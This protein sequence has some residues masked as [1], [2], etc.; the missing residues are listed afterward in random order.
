MGNILIVDDSRVA[1]KVLRHV[2]ETDGHIV[3][4]EAADGKQGI[5][6]Y[7][8]LRPDLVLMDMIMPVM[9]GL[10]CLKAIKQYDMWAKV[11]FVSASA[12]ERLMHDATE[13]GCA[14]FI[15]KPYD[16]SVLLLSIQRVL[17]QK[18]DVEYHIS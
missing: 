12:T 3:V 1:R 9:N 8:Q 16:N 11:I 15:S 17:K 14:D 10:E 2:L 7:K 5:Q 4:G 6:L 18:S 13:Y